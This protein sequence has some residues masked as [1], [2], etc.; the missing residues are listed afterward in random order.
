M[1]ELLL[2]VLLMILVAGGV[3]LLAVWR[4]VRW[5]RRSPRLRR[6]VRSVQ[7]LTAPPGARRQVA[8]LRR[9]LNAAA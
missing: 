9:D 3:A 7:A 2:T 8:C 4:V 6:R 5:V 1:E